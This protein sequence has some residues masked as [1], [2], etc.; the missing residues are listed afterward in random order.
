MRPNC[1]SLELYLAQLYHKKEKKKIGKKHKGEILLF[2][3]VI[4]QSKLQ[5][6]INLEPAFV[7]VS[8]KN[9]G[10]GL[11]RWSLRPTA[12]S[13]DELRLMLIG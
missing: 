6:K 13:K 4:W 2:H 9:A 5:Q 3:T 7:L 8:N 1:T 10:S 11:F 12:R